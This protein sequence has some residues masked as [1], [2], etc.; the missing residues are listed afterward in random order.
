METNVRKLFERYENISK[1]SLRGDVD[2][3]DVAALHASEFVAAT[4]A[5]VMTGKND[6]H[7]KQ[8]IAEGYAP[9]RLSEQRRCTCGDSASRR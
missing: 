1:A 2:M 6:E 8:V 3:D 9:Y 7:L 4:P 5:G